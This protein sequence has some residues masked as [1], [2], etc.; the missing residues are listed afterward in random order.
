MRP[1]LVSSVTRSQAV[2]APARL[3][4]RTM[5]T[6]SVIAR[7][8]ATTVQRAANAPASGPHRDEADRGPGWAHDLEHTDQNE[9]ASAHQGGE[10]EEWDPVEAV[11]VH[12]YDRFGDAEGDVAEPKE[13]TER[14]CGNL[15]L[16]QAE[17]IRWST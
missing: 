2:F 14:P 6:I 3:V 10:P 8:G 16:H 7:N 5:N 15:S 4:R 11:G 1:P 13:R 17:S 9:D 12:V